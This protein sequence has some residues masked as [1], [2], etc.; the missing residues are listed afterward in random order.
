MRYGDQNKQ[1]VQVRYWVTPQ[2]AQPMWATP[3]YV[4]PTF[5][6]VRNTTNDIV[7]TTIHNTRMAI[8]LPTRA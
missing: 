7:T 6:G 2:P 3:N 1:N 8:L 5:L 4:Y